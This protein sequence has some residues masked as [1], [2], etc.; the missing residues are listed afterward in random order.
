MEVVT[1]GHLVRLIAINSSLPLW[2]FLFRRLDRSL[3]SVPD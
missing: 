1:A 3:Q 2:L